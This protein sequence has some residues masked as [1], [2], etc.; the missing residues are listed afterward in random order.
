MKRLLLLF[1][2]LAL[3]VIVPFLIWGNQVEEAMTL[4]GTVAR[5]RAAGDWAW[6]VGVALLVIDLFLPILGTVVMSALWLIYGWSPA[7]SSAQ[8]GPSPPAC[9]PTDSAAASDAVPP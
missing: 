7:G 2:V 5:M 4:E 8:S 1:C 9:S 6:L 3:F